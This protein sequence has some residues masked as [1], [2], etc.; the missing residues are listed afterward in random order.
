MFRG[1]LVKRISLGNE[2]YSVHYRFISKEIA[3]DTCPKCGKSSTKQKI[4]VTALF[5]RSNIVSTTGRL[6]KR[7]FEKFKEEIR[8][9]GV[10][11]CPNPSFHQIDLVFG[12]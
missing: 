5:E 10:Y 3:E 12:P 11:P 7:V 1:T 6:S 2:R 9:E 8:L 4:L